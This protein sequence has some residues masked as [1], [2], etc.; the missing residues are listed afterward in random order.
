MFSYFQ[1]ETFSNVLSKLKNIFGPCSVLTVTVLNCVVNGI[2]TTHSVTCTDA[3][4]YVLV[5]TFQSLIA[6]QLGGF[7]VVEKCK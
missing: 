3:D 2:Q 6:G 1:R 5:S 7:D 4:E